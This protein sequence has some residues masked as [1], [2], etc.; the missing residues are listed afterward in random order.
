MPTSKQ[1]VVAPTFNLSTWDAKAGRSLWTGGQPDLD[2][3]L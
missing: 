2:I 3:E 1:S